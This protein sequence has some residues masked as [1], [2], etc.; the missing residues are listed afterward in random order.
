MNTSNCHASLVSS[1]L[2][3]FRRIL[4]KSLRPVAGKENGSGNA[5]TSSVGGASRGG[6]L[7]PTHADGSVTGIM[8][9]P[10]QVPP[11]Q[12][13][14]QLPWVLTS[15]SVYV[16]VPACLPA[17]PP[18]VYCIN[19]AH[20]LKQVASDLVCLKY[21]CLWTNDLLHALNYI[22]S[23]DGPLTVCHMVFWSWKPSI[24]GMMLYRCD[25]VKT[26]I[27]RLR[28]TCRKLCQSEF[29]PP[30]LLAGKTL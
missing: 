15:L 30:M 4:P 1:C 18:Y 27:Y 9:S 11:P 29:Q 16:C 25:Q 13:T 23:P 7:P 28:G 20:Q 21:A 6:P 24:A 2:Q 10:R 14:L 8:Y 22:A 26:C 19:H 3:G 17:F 5:N 12:G